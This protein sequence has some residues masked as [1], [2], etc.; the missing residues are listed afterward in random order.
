MTSRRWI[1]GRCGASSCAEI[2]APSSISILRPRTRKSI[3]AALQFVRKVSGS[4]RRRNA[5]RQPSIGRLKQIGGAVHE[6]LD[7]LQT[8]SP[9]RDREIEVAKRQA[10]AAARFS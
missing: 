9:P 7:A 10:R 1:S 2:F 4:T 8:S 5:M 6:L 3:D